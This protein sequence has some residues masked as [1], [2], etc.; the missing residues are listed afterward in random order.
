MLESSAD[1]FDGGRS[2][3]A[4]FRWSICAPDRSRSVHDCD[5]RNEMSHEKSEKGQR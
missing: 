3:P 5:R 2:D 1:T 4:K